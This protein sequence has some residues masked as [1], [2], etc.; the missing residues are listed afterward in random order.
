MAGRLSR[1][2]QHRRCLKRDRR[3]QRNG[4]DKVNEEQDFP[5]RIFSDYAEYYVH[6]VSSASSG[7]GDD[8]RLVRNYRMT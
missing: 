2:G 7:S 1:R 4:Q 3:E 6:G 8:A 5:E